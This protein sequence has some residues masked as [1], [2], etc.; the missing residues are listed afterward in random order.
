MRTALLTL[1]LIAGT[2]TPAFASECPL[3]HAQVATAVGNRFDAGAHTAKGLAAEGE[4][5]HKDGKHVDSVK[6][7]EEAAKAAGITLKRK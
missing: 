2:V 4:K 6:K 3:L 5:L 7:Y 1:G